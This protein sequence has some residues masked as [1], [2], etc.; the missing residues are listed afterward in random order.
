MLKIIIAED[1]L[2]FRQSLSNF[3]QMD[4]DVEKVMEAS[5]GEEVLD[6]LAKE[7]ADIV[8]TDIEM[9]VMDG[10][11]LTRELK[12]CRPDLPVI[13]M[14]MYEE[15][16]LLSEMIR[17]GARGYVLKKGKIEQ[18]KE[19]VKAVLTNG[20]YFCNDSSSKLKEMLSRAHPE[21]EI[22][23]DEGLLSDTEIQI[24][25]LTCEGLSTKQVAEKMFRSTRTIETYK[26]NIYQKL[27]IKKSPELVVFA[28]RSGIYKP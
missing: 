23:V 26:H 1:Q 7:N 2:M 13:A 15:D 5:N 22:K 20:Y 14:T 25:Q 6:I 10:I 16:L 3:I 28:I 27:D 21:T 24:I 4:D 9:P 11:T 18:L 12:Q 17:A 19:A 8:I